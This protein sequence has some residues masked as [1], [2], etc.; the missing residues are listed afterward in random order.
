MARDQARTTIA[1]AGVVGLG[2]G[3]G[4]GSGQAQRLGG[5]HAPFQL[6]PLGGHFT[7]LGLLA[8]AGRDQELVCSRSNSARLM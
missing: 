6:D 4:I 7:G 2:I 1:A 5:L 3:I 8:G